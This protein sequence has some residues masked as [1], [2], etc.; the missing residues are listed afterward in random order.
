MRPFNVLFKNI[1]IR[2]T[3][4]LFVYLKVKIFV[5]SFINVKFQLTSKS[6]YNK[7]AY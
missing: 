5:L 6:T 7:V 4:S 2:K 3:P 1:S